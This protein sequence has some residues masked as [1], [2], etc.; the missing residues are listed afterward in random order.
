MIT[1]H[2]V[3]VQSTS[4]DMA[5]SRNEGQLYSFDRMMD[6]N[7][8]EVMTCA[9]DSKRLKGFAS[10]HTLLPMRKHCKLLVY[11]CPLELCSVNFSLTAPL[12]VFL[13]KPVVLLN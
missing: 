10:R 7:T 9:K 4:H 2:K 12:Q 11:G 3:F 6:K 8:G 1:V 13:S 5:R